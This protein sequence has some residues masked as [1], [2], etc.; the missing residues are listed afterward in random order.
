MPGPGAEPLA[1]FVGR[2]LSHVDG[3][4][5][6]ATHAHT[7]IDIRMAGHRHRICQSVRVRTAELGRLWAGGNARS[8][9]KNSVFVPRHFVD[10]HP[11]RLNPYFALRSLIRVTSN[12]AVGTSNHEFTAPNGRH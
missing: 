7:G 12:F 1:I 2:E 5:P 6:I 9:E 3:G 4:K 11:E 8:L 10:P